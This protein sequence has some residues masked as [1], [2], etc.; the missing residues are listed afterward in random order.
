MN[1]PRCVA[2]LLILVKAEWRSYL[3][4]NPAWLDLYNAAFLELDLAKLPERV[5]AACKGIHPYRVEKG[6]TL[7]AEERRELDDALRVLFTLIQGK[8]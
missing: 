4:R 7:T 2:G 1:T 6:Q 5:E 8:A 3:S